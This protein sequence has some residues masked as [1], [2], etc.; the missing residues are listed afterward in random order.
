[1]ATDL[2]KA[3]LQSEHPLFE[4]TDSDGHQYKIFLNGTI[5]GFRPDTRIVKWFIPLVNLLR[6]QANQKS[7]STLLPASEL[8]E[9]L[10]GMSHSSA[11]ER[12]S[13]R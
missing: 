8:T 2:F 5:E 13:S 12:S 11:T 1:M 9:S 10:A 7:K 4:A 6:S 3:M